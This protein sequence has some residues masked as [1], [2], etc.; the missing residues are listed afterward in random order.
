MR[1]RERR[2]RKSKT[3]AMYYQ[4]GVHWFSDWDKVWQPAESWKKKHYKLDP[5]GNPIVNQVIF[6]NLITIDQFFWNLHLCWLYPPYF[7]LLETHQVPD[8]AY[9]WRLLPS[10]LSAPS[11]SPSKLLWRGLRGVTDV[12]SSMFEKTTLL[13]CWW[14]HINAHIRNHDFIQSTQY[15]HDKPIIIKLYYPFTRLLV[16]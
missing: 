16:T 8:I 6:V 4:I 7:P 3:G 9:P 12:A 14:Y 10:L 5:P 11:V 13:Y 2:W 15:Y 1:F